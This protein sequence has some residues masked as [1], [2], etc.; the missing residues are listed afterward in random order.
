M[1]LNGFTTPKQCKTTQ[2]QICETLGPFARL[3]F[4]KFG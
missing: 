3:L 2:P 1:R 4:F